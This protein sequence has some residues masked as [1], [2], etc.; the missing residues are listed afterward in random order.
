MFGMLHL[1]MQ[2]GGRKKVRSLVKKG[3]TGP[4]PCVN[5][6]GHPKLVGWCTNLEND[7]EREA[8]KRQLILTRVWLGEAESADSGCKPAGSEG[9]NGGN[10]VGGIRFS[11]LRKQARPRIKH[12]SLILAQDERWRRA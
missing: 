4:C 2:S 3:L 1:K 11:D 8:N 5:L 9:S 6:L 7:T 10:P 12:K